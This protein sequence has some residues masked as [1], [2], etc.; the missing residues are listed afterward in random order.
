MKHLILVLIG[1][2]PLA[3]SAGGL[4]ERNANIGIS[5]KLLLKI[6]LA[7]SFLSSEKRFVSYG[8]RSGRLS[9][10]TPEEPREVWGQD[11]PGYQDFFTLPQVAGAALWN[12]KKLYITEQNAA[13]S[14]EIATFTRYAQAASNSLAFT[15]VKS[16]G[17]SFKIIKQLSDQ[18]WQ[19]ENFEPEWPLS[20]SSTGLYELVTSLSPSG[21]QLMALDL[22]GNAFDLH[23]EDSG[24]RLTPVLED[25][26][27]FTAITPNDN[28]RALRWSQDETAIYLGTRQ[29]NIHQLKTADTCAG[30]DAI[31]EIALPQAHAILDIQ[32]D[33]NQQ[34]FVS[35]PGLIT[36]VDSRT[37]SIVASTPTSCQLPMGA[38]A[39]DDSHLL[40]ACLVPSETVDP[41]QVPLALPLQDEIQYIVQEFSQGEERI[42]TF[43]DSAIGGLAI[44]VETRRLHMMSGSRLGF[45]ETYDLLTGDRKVSS[46]LLIDGVLN[47]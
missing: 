14:F 15:F 28:F 12:E 26:T 25:C 39:L 23:K 8:R 45:L 4:R 16:S 34:L 37:W 42:F 20:S 24:G 35:Q 29:G 5:D 27:T 11:L 2:F 19:V 40:I 47:P 21:R 1:A 13:Q 6:G 41:A 9:V 33:K 18:S 3:C 22:F 38:L 32:E 30:Q 31:P 36:Q 7:R 43:Q 46:G 44:D 10:V 17:D